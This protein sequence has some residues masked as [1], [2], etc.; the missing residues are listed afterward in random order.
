[1]S[2]QTEAVDDNLGRTRLSHTE[3]DFTLRAPLSI[4]E[5]KVEYTHMYQKIQ[6]SPLEH[7]LKGAT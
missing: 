7:F 4:S 5:L 2:L 1:M 3:M 6:N